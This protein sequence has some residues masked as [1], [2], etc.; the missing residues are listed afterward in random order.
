M[1]TNGEHRSR[2]ERSALK[3]RRVAEE[4]LRPLGITSGVERGASGSGLAGDRCSAGD[5]D[6]LVV[7]Q[8]PPFGLTKHWIV[9]ASRKR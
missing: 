8:R 7:D 5:H 1:V 3:R 6:G 4:D 9:S 2:M